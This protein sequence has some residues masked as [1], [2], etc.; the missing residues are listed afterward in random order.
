MQF[1]SPNPAYLLRVCTQHA[2]L[3]KQDCRNITIVSKIGKRN[4]DIIE[5]DSGFKD[6]L[7]GGL[8]TR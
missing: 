5:G 7:R 3:L 1:L 4:L 8:Y 2:A 6:R